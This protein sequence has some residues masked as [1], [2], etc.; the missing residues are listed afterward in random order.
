MGLFSRK[1]EPKGYQPTD[2]EI[3]NAAKKLNAGSQDAAYNLTAHSGDYRQQ[4]AMRIL[5]AS[6][7]DSEES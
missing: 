2:A 1:S 7:D 4:T 3:R 6:V 5:A